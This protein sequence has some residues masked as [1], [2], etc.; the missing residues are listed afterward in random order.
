MF[1][2]C[3]YFVDIIYLCRS[4]SGLYFIFNSYHILFIHQFCL[5]NN[6]SLLK[7]YCSVS[8]VNNHDRKL[9]LFVWFND[10]IGYHQTWLCPNITIFNWWNF[11]WFHLVQICILYCQNKYLLFVV[12][13]LLYLLAWLWK[14]YGYLLQVVHMF[15]PLLSNRDQNINEP[16]FLLTNPCLK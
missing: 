5:S 2:W 10:S 12:L 13:I 6:T 3:I 9:S 11:I 7:F 15:F 14:Q 16:H 8:I 4:F 1:F